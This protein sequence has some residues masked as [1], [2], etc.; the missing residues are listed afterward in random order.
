MALTTT[1]H[2]VVWPAF[3]LALSLVPADPATAAVTHIQPVQVDKGELLPDFVT[4]D[5]S[6]DFEGNLRGH[7]ILLD[8]DQGSIYDNAFGSDYPP[9]SALFP[10]FPELAYDTFV[11]LGGPTQQESHPIEPGSDISLPIVPECSILPG[12]RLFAGRPATG[13]AIPSANDFM[14]ARITLSNDA[15]GTVH[16]FGATT[17]SSRFV[18]GFSIVQGVIQIPEPASGIMLTLACFAWSLASRRRCFQ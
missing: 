13:V 4:N 18:A 9:N 1:W 5:L 2:R 3:L 8:L 14:V 15:M 16:Y 10:I 11:T 17:D 12:C 6:I 7:L